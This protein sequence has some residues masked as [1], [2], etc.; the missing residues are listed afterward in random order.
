MNLFWHLEYACFFSKKREF[1]GELSIEYPP[2]RLIATL[3][4]LETT[5]P[6]EPLQAFTQS[7][8]NKCSFGS[9][10]GQHLAAECCAYNSIH[11]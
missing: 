11:S 1:I 7:I 6:D 8:S 4:R 5:A 10:W 9:C 2:E 3:A